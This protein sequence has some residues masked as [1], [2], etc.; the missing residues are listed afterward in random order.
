MPAMIAHPG[1]PVWQT[2]ITRDLDQAKEFYGPLFG[3]EFRDEDPG[4][5]RGDAGR[6]DH[7]E[8]GQPWHSMGAVLPR[9][10]R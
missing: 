1:M 3:W 2:L 10:E 9:R 8:P 7:R 5:E 4:Y 6:R